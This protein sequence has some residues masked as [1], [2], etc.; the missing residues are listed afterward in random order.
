M[1]KITT[2]LA[3]AA[4]LVLAGSTGARAQTQN[5]RPFFAD[6]NIGAQTQSRTIDTSTSFPL[7]GETAVIN[8]SQ[9]VDGGALF[10]FSGGYRV[11]PQFGVAVGVSIFS[12]SGAGALA[13][14]IP[15]PI[16]LNKPATSTATA[17]DLKHREVATHIMVSYVRPIAEDFEVAVFAG[18]SFFRLTQDVLSATVPAGTQNTT[19]ATQSEKANATGGNVGVNVNYTLGPNYGVGVFLRYAGTTVDLPSAAG[20]K[21]GGFQLGIGLRLRF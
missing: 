12:K 2:P 9:A 3:L 19:V 20:V 21:V 10:D 15:S 11:V 16:A 14:S 7:Y 18:P 6:V 13:S 8:A 1:T 5:A 4:A 17:T